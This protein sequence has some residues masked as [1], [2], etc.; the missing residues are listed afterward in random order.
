MEPNAAASSLGDVAIVSDSSCCLP[1]DL[2]ARHGITV[3]P[4]ALLID[5]HLYH[6]GELTPEQ[7]REK[8]ASAEK[9]P[10]T[11]VPAPGEFLEVFRKLQE[12]GRNSVLCLTLSAA[13]SGTYS[14]AV[15]AAEMARRELPDL[16]LVILDTGGLAMAHGLAVL[17]A[18]RA[19]EAGADLE[20][21]AAVARN[22]ASRAHLVGALDTML[23]LAKSGRV[24]WIVHWAASM[25]Q[26]K[27][28]LAAYDGHVR[29][30]GRPRT[31]RNALT[32]LVRYLEPRAG[33]PEKLHV[34]VAHYDAPERAE[35][36]AARVREQLNPGEMFVTE[37]T[38][39]MSVHA[40]PGFVGLAFYSDAPPEAA[41][42]RAPS[43]ERDADRLEAAL[44]ELPAAVER[45]AFIML[46]G[47]PGA[48][49]SR[50]AEEIA[51]LT[52]VAL[53]ESDRLRK[54]LIARPTY[55]PGES[56]RTFEAIH[57]LLE[58]LLR[59]GVPCLLDATNL[60]EEH[61]RPLYEIAERTSARL[62]VVAVEAPAEVALSRAA[63]RGAE[64]TSD[65]GPAVFE[66]MREDAEPIEHDHLV[67]DGTGDVG[68][69]AARVV[70]EMGR[71]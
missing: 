70:E 51:G 38:P 68:A 16:R 41:P 15:N 31:I 44:G 40:G 13:Y 35:D 64:D 50:L 39:V 56:T 42:A 58:R 27:P 29:S 30:F 25:L 46:S 22:V 63:G 49:K 14:A 55:A 4:L 53:L 48:G 61:R 60:R 37:F 57:A 11:T 5:G 2:V 47:L 33:E 3:V 18:A 65:A 54:A 26:I 10:S 67:V 20:E 34:A 59:R 45:P 6:D 12:A 21:A 66:K 1:P 52:P 17:A 69:E 28:V 43:A 71:G 23:Y 19:A 9:P 24:P 8:L 32:R 7:F 62:L 36:L